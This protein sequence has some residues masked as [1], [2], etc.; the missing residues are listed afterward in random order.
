MHIVFSG[1]PGAVCYIVCDPNYVF[2]KKNSGLFRLNKLASQG[3]KIPFAAIAV[4][5]VLICSTGCRKS[6]PPVTDAT[7]VQ[8]T[9]QANQAA[10]DHAQAFQ[11]PV[12]VAPVAVNT[13]ATGAPDLRELDRS[14]IR[15][16]VGN[17]R[18]PKNFAD[19]AATAG[20]AIPP[21]PAG[22][23]YI[24]DKTMHIQLVDL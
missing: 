9:N 1:H 10:E 15:W 24:I 4:L 7:A 2:M 22:K 14:L 12:P 13:P 6:K 23:K 18:P 3:S 5:A 20:V 17:R 19:F 8:D 11:P 21:P 16:I